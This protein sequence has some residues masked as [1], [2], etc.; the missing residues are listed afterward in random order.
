MMVSAHTLA[1]APKILSSL[2]LGEVR[3]LGDDLEPDD[4][5]DLLCFG[6]V[7]LGDR[8]CFLVGDELDFFFMLLEFL[9]FVLDL[10]PALFLLVVLD[11]LFTGIG[12]ISTS[13]EEEDE[14]QSPSPPIDA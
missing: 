6:D 4:V 13:M 14:D 2:V 3:L 5:L 7:F 11:G 1:G 9:F 8:L 10:M 12:S